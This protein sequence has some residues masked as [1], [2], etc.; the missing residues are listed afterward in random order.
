MILRLLC[1]GSRENILPPYMLP[2]TGC[3]PF[4]PSSLLLQLSTFLRC[5]VFCFSSLL[6]SF[7]S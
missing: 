3:R 6:L 1:R 2:Y 7:N 4:S 5:S